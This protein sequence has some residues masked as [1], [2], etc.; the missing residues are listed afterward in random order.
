MISLHTIDSSLVSQDYSQ[1]SLPAGT[2]KRLGKGRISDVLNPPEIAYSPDGKS[3]AVASANGIWIYDAQTAKE[4][5][6]L[7]G[8]TSDVTSVSFCP[9]GKTLASSSWDKTVRLWD[10]QTGKHLRTF[11]GHIGM[12]YTVVFSPDG[13]TLAS[14]SR[15][16][17]LLLW[18]LVSQNK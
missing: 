18:D 2:K 1:W 3:F 16:G 17:S 15:D 10:T 7:T 9:D 11:H 4:L 12:I 13:K 14:G 8:H 5:N 6:L